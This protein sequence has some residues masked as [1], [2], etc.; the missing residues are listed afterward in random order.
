MTEPTEPRTWRTNLTESDIGNGLVPEDWPLDP[1]LVSTV[2]P[3]GVAVAADGRMVLLP[4]AP[5]PEG[6]EWYSADENGWVQNAL[7]TGVVSCEWPA[8]CRPVPAPEPATQ[9]V[10]WAEAVDNRD[11]ARYVY[12]HPRG[13]V[14][15]IYGADFSVSPGCVRNAVGDRICD[16]D[17]DGLVTVL[18]DADPTPT[19]KTLGD[20]LDECPT[21]ADKLRLLFAGQMPTPTDPPSDTAATAAMQARTD[22]WQ[23]AAPEPKHRPGYACGNVQCSGC[24]PMLGTPRNAPSVV[25]ADSPD[26]GRWKRYGPDAL[27][28]HTHDHEPRTLYRSE[29]GS[30]LFDA[31]A[32][33][34]VRRDRPQ[35][36]AEQVRA[37]LIADGVRPPATETIRR[38]LAAV[39][40]CRTT[41]GTGE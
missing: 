17:D 39:D 6:W 5:L 21:E 38:V 13:P 36:T 34:L 41:E 18:R 15:T 12:D 29:V 25:P 14:G 19:D 7:T 26:T 11:E 1:V 31:L 9:R 20:A 27:R 24:Y 35:P 33:A 3:D 4:G 22:A 8:V 40:A 23:N 37:Q 32:A 2:P 16:I 30:F 28:L 10:P